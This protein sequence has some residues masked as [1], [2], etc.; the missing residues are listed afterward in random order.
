M[1]YTDHVV[2]AAA[3][4]AKWLLIVSSATAVGIRF[5]EWWRRGTKP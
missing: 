1:S 5:V 4:I 2:S 3:K